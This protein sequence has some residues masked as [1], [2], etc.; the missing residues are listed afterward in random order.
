MTKSKYSN[1]FWHQGVRIFEEEILKGVEGNIRI[2]HLENDVTKA[3]FNLFEHCS[4]KV[5]KSFLKL[6]NIH[7]SPNTFEFEFQIHDTNKFRNSPHRIMLSIISSSTPQ[8]QNGNN[9]ITHTIPDGAIY[10]NSKVVLIESKTQSPLY[11]N[12]IESHIKNYLGTATEERI[13]TWEDL[14]ETLK[15]LKKSADKFDSFLIEQF[16]DF[17]EMIGIAE[18]KGF[19]KDD[20]EMLDSIGKIS[21]EEYLD[22]KRIFC[23]KID[24][25]MDKLDAL[26][27]DDL[28]KFKYDKRYTKSSSP[29][30][31][32]YFYD[33][34][35]DESVN[36]YP[37]ININYG[38]YGIELSLNAGTKSAFSYFLEKINK[39]EQKFN[40][41]I[42]KLKYFDIL[43]VYKIQYRP[44]NNFIWD[45]VPG[46]PKTLKNYNSEEL[47]ND[48]HTFS[49]IWNNI[50]TTTIH[51][52]QIGL[53]RRAN[54]EFYLEGDI[55]FARKRN[56]HPNT[57][58]KIDKRYQ[59]DFIDSQKEKIIP[60]F[61]KEILKLK[62]LLDFLYEGTEVEKSKNDLTQIPL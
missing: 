11:R 49:N 1:I 58:L 53:L 35:N 2:A 33:K 20:F 59:I 39:N 57:I 38:P 3:L 50:L 23:K 28:S 54:H 32:F 51:K 56:P 19:K 52:M 27:K 21:D 9:L 47:H 7:D 15:T 43:V 37:N 45:F 22:Y 36:K 26:V 8:I 40:K 42:S 31:A 48:L 46:Y 14:S 25:F 13:L 16:L 17:L 24:K 62:D 10:S 12:Q 29:W 34:E 60:F 61:K 5:L 55:E 4:K 41:L 44:K 30:S 18:F 6:I